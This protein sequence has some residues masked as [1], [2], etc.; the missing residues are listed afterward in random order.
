MLVLSGPS[1]GGKTTIASMLTEQEPFIVHS[2]SATT[3]KPRG[4]EQDGEDYFFLSTED[5]EKRSKEGYFL[6][7]AKFLDNYYGTPRGPVEEH[8]MHGRD[9]VFDIEWQGAQQLAKAAPKDAVRVFLLP[10]SIPE[11]AKRLVGRNTETKEAVAR[12]LTQAKEDM[13]HWEEY[14]YVFVN[15][16]LEQTL[17]RIRRILRAERLKRQRQPW[18][19]EFAQ[20][21][22]DSCD[23]VPDIDFDRRQA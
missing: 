20:N 9:V 14:D 17:R 1:G 10:P 11:L 18:V 6:E 13:Q 22:I 3:R 7:Y 5:F 12:R 8:L 15:E 19:K 4:E 16:N 2:I 23:E 21:L